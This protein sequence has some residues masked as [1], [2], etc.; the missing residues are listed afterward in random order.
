MS[1]IKPMALAAL[2]RR[3][4]AEMAFVRMPHFLPDSHARVRMSLSKAAFA[5]LM[6]PP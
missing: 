3:G 1:S 2:L 4:P 6:P 5:E